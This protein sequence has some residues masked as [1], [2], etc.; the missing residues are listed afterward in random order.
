MK[1]TTA[2]A[3]IDGL[4]AQKAAATQLQTAKRAIVEEVRQQVLKAIANQLPVHPQLEYVMP[5][6]LVDTAFNSARKRP[7]PETGVLFFRFSI[8]PHWN[9]YGFT[10][11]RAQAICA[12]FHPYHTAVV[13]EIIRQL[14]S[15]GE[16]KLVEGSIFCYDDGPNGSIWSDWAMI[17]V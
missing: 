12:A 15:K 3:Y 6:G 14:E 4:A 8:N 17:P 10:R 2:N 9:E 7:K 1:S 5:A 16:W 11:E 13:T